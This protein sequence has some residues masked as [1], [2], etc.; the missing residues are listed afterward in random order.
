MVRVLRVV[1]ILAEAVVLDVVQQDVIQDVVVVV[2]G[3]DV[4]VAGV[5]VGKDVVAVGEIL[6]NLKF[7]KITKF[8]VDVK[9]GF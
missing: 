7:T 5:D 2:V 3:K 4:A 8:Y 6:T 9:F 1:V